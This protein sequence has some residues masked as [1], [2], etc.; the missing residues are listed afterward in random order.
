MNRFAELNSLPYREKSFNSLNGRKMRR[1]DKT[2]KDETLHAKSEKRNRRASIDR[3]EQIVNKNRIFLFIL[4]RNTRLRN[5][6]D[7]PRQYSNANEYCRHG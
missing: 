4:F 2:G 1:R 7:F 3:F 6:H 5:I